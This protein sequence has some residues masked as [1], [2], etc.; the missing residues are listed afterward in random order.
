MV[1]G[2]QKAG[3]WPVIVAELGG[4]VVGFG[5]IGMFRTRPAYKYSGEHSVHVHADHR[6]KGI[7]GALLR[8]SSKKRNAWSSVRWSVAS[9]QGTPE[10]SPSIPGTASLNAR[11]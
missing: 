4:Q 3:N 5:S 1:P 11:G 10:A 8:R 9:I 7:G 2:G 6:G